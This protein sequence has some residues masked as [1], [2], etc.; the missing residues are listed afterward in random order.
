M[1]WEDGFN[2]PSKLEVHGNQKCLSPFVSVVY[3]VEAQS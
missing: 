1:E 3:E 2:C